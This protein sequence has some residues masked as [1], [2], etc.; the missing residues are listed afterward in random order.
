MICNGDKVEVLLGLHKGTIGT[1][2]NVDTDCVEIITV[3]TEKGELNFF[4]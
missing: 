1:V 3:L 4:P 2:V